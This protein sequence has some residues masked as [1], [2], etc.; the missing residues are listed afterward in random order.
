VK[1]RKNDLTMTISTGGKTV[2]TTVEELGQL[3]N[4]ITSL[5]NIF[6]EAKGQIDNL[7]LSHQM[8]VYKAYKENGNEL[9]ISLS[10]DLKG[11]SQF[12]NIKTKISFIAE[13]VT[14]ELEAMIKL[15]QP[16]LPMEE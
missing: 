16:N 8:G 14:D 5:D 12:V 4:E 9:K 3:S 7:L 10:V 13:K 6:K 15:N 1:T 11:D 2:E